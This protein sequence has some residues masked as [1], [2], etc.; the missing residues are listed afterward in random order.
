VQFTPTGISGVT[1]V[2]LEPHVDE[3]GL[4]ARVWCAEELAGAGLTDEIA[5]CSISRNPRAGTLRGLHYQRAPHEEA[6][7]VR[8]TRGAIFDVAVDVRDASPTR[9]RWFGVELSA[10]NGCALFVPEGCAHGFQTLVDDT[11]VLYFISRPYAPD[12]GAGIRWDD[13][14]LA[15]A[16]PDT[17]SRTISDRDLAWPPFTL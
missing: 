14:A 16:W 12:A 8:C 3:R 1:V 11:D 15:I 9:G 5:Q 10:E 7:L 6:K 4:F 2:G 17:E 13:G